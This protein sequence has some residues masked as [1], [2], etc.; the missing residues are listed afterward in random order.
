MD[1]KSRN[2]ISALVVAFAL[3]LG[4]WN[5]LSELMV[6]GGKGLGSSTSDNLWLL[7]LAPRNLL[8]LLASYSSGS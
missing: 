3:E 1:E 8:L 2:S 7:R 6:V 4:H 5:D